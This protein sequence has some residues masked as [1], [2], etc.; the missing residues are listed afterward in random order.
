M[1]M[2][3]K[4]KNIYAMSHKDFDAL[5][6][7]NGWNDADGAAPN[8]AI[9]SICCSPAFREKYFKRHN[10]RDEHWFKCN[11][12]RNV[13]NVDFDDIVEES[14]ETEYGTAYG[15]SDEQAKQIVKF[16][17]DNRDVDEWYIHCHAGI[18]R[19]VAVAAWIRNY[20]LNN[21]QDAKAHTAHGFMGENAFVYKKL[22]NNDKDIS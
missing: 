16:V 10:T 15:I 3:T 22:E 5:M 19:S 17:K 18:S 9:I 2:T 4:R 1:S 6:E 21:K 13:L 7:K 11:D 20:Y 12:F 8:V 14:R